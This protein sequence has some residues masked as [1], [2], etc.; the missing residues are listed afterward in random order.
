MN[1]LPSALS[2]HHPGRPARPA[3][4]PAQAIDGSPLIM[5]GLDPE[6]DLPA[7][8]QLFSDVFSQPMPLP[9]WRW[10]YM[11][12]PGSQ[13]YH[14][15]A[16]HAITG[17]L[18][19]HMGVIIQP[20]VLGGQAIRMAHATDLMISPVARNGLGPDSVY[21]HIMQTV[22]ERAFEAGP[23]APPLFM[24]GFPGQRPATL[25]MRLGIQRRL[26]ICTE[27]P[28]N[29]AAASPPAAQGLWARLL[30]PWQQ[31]HHLRLQACPQPSKEAA[32]SDTA[33]NPIWLRHA[34]ALAT[35]DV[36]STRPTITKTAAYLRWRYLQHPQQQTQPDGAPLY[37]LWL[38]NRPGSTPEGWLVTRQ[39]PRPTV[40]D[41]CLPGDSPT[42]AR[43]VT[44]AL[45]ALNQQRPGPW[46]TWLP[47]PGAQPLPT[48]IWATAMQGAQF[49]DQWLSP[50]FQP[51][52]TDVF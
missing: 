20:G 1:H 33:L 52:D 10:K 27:Y 40:V 49:H 14:A 23:A 19:G 32:W 38:L 36:Q 9:Y 29:P 7:I 17:Q 2:S 12:A 18:L 13:H 35:Q 11:Q 39:S 42:R 43:W 30:Q 26:Q 24:Y 21:R 37:T 28:F 41:S 15:V 31:R 46:T 34:S 5:R 22:R 50:K 4:R 51:G 3:L 25:A 48:P 44:A 6:R 47:H 45:S 16:A 8:C